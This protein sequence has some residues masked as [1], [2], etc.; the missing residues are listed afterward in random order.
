MYDVTTD[1]PLLTGA[2]HETVSA[3]SDTWSTTESGCVGTV[4]GVT[5]TGTELGLS[6]LALVATTRKAYSVPFVNPVAVYDV[7]AVV[8]IRVHTPLDN[9]N[10]STAYEPIGAPPLLDGADQDSVTCRSP[11]TGVK[12]VGAAGMAT[13]TAFTVLEADPVPAPLTA[14]TRTAYD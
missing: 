12:A 6:P 9:T 4:A 14:L 13:G 3:E 8:P 7:N 2:F 11:A 1:P 5:F 10:R